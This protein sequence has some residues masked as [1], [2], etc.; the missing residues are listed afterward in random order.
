MPSNSV[1]LLMAIGAH[2]QTARIASVAT[3]HFISAPPISTAARRN[4]LSVRGGVS[5][6]RTARP[7]LRGRTGM[8]EAQDALLRS[9]GSG[10]GHGGET[11][12]EPVPRQLFGDGDGMD[13][14][15]CRNTRTVLR[16]QPSSAA[17]R[18]DPQPSDFSRI[19]ADTSSGA[20]IAS[21]RRSF[22]RGEASPTIPSNSL[23]GAGPQRRGDCLI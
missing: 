10:V 8:C 6:R 20:F 16:E 4:R 14:I 12:S 2:V 3:R 19:I 18:F 21:L 1:L 7:P 17:I 5:R 22:V 9:W 15:A 13:A 23:W 11:V